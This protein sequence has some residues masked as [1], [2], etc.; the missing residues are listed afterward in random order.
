MSPLVPGVN[1][2]MKKSSPF[3]PGTSGDIW[4]RLREG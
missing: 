1:G 2:D 3:T 4:G